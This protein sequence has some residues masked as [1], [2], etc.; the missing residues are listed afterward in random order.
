MLVSL[1]LPII[2]TLA[3][4]YLLIKFRFF[5]VRHPIRTAKSFIS[6]LSDRDTRRSFFLALAGTLGVGNIFGVAAGIMIGGPGS[7]FWL[8]L[9]G[10]FSMIIKYAETLLVF[11][12]GI[13]RGGMSAVFK[14]IFGK[15]GHSMSI[16]YALLTLF[17]SLSMG[18][19]MQSAAVID[20]ARQGLSVHPITSLVILVVLLIPCIA[21]RSEKIESITEIVIPMT[22]IIYI[23]MCF[24]VIFIN[25]TRIHDVINLIISSAFSFRSAAG[26]MTFLMV[27][28]GFARGIL[29]NEAGAGTSAMAHSRSRNRSS[30]TAGLFAMSEVF[31]DSTLLCTLTGI[32][33][34]LSVPDL[35]DF[36]T[37]MALVNA[38]FSGIG[39][40]ASSLL[41]F[42]ILAFAYSTLIC[43][44]YYGSECVGIH[45]PL[46]K[47]VYPIAFLLTVI[48]SAFISSTL[49]ISVIDILLLFMTLMTLSAILKQSSRLACVSFSQQKNPEP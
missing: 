46:F 16:L 31:F 41:P 5:F 19:A 25:F 47:R 40:G 12:S 21:G 32:S 29:S 34:L 11:D 33:I 15:A 18:S 38:A 4:L 27:K 7:I 10:I 6:A 35:N 44:Y 30:H 13:E 48:F 9:S 22:T 2:V 49:M 14:R 45:F 23:L 1:F 8:F 42:I 17:L 36:K 20:V 37:P 39:K 28:E 43:W 3:G 26:G 24:A